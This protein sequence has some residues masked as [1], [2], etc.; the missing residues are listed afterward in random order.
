MRLQFTVVGVAEQAGSKR[1]FMPKGW[2]RPILTD[3]NPRLKSWQ[4]LVA[5][6]AHVAIMQLPSAERA[7]ILGGVRLMIVFY[8]PRPVSLSYKVTAHTKKPDIDK[9]V[10]AIQDA[11]SR[12]V[13]TDDAQVVDLIAMKRYARGNEVPHVDVVVEPSAGVE[14]LPADVPLFELIGGVSHGEDRAHR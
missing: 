5:E 3:G 9:C 7:M 14:L 13:F 8:L 1:A 11:L 12:V 10:R 4:Q 2:K 6:A